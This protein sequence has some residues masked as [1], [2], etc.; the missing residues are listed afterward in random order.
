MMNGFQWSSTGSGFTKYSKQSTQYTTWNICMANLLRQVLDSLSRT[1][2]AWDM[3]HR[4][5]I[6][7]FLH[8]EAPLDNTPTAFMPLHNIQGLL[9]ELKGFEQDLQDLKRELSESVCY[10]SGLSGIPLE[11]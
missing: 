2:R 4:S 10:F 3:F 9:L 5:D 11:R 8:T 1:N 6:R 7:Y